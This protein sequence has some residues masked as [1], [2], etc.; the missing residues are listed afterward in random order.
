MEIT[1]NLKSQRWGS[2][3]TRTDG[4]ADTRVYKQFNKIKSNLFVAAMEVYQRVE[5]D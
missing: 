5:D 1:T 2:E 3:L 4:L